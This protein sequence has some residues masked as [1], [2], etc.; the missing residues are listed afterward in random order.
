VTGHHVLHAPE[1]VLLCVKP[2][3]FDLPDLSGTPFG[4]LPSP[5]TVYMLPQTQDPNLIWP[6]W[7]TELIPA[8]S[9]AVRCRSTSDWTVPAR[10]SCGR[11]MR[12][13]PHLRLHRRRV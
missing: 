12:S 6:R 9:S 13:V 5:G 1:D 4:F 8:G 2:E 3:A 10:S 7:S 11:T